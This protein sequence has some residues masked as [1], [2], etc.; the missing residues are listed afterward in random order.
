[1]RTREWTDRHRMD[2]TGVSRRACLTPHHSSEL[3]QVMPPRFSLISHLPLDSIAA[4]IFSSDFFFCC[5]LNCS[6]PTEPLCLAP[7]FSLFQIRVAQAILN[8]LVVQ[9]FLFRFTMKTQDSKCLDHKICGSEVGYSS[10][11]TKFHSLNLQN[12]PTLPP[13]IPPYLAALITQFHLTTDLSP[14]TKVILH[15]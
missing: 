9:P 1:V 3:V 5:A 7:P 6:S 12:Q 8:K 4:M 2:T 11:K 15:A 10:L 14:L 13:C